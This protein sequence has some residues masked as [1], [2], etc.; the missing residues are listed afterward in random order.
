MGVIYSYLFINYEKKEIDICV[1]CNNKIMDTHYTLCK[2]CTYVSHINCQIKQQKK[3]ECITC[4]RGLSI[5]TILTNMV[6]II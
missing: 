6:K 4:N 1:I 5:T 3:N 2:T